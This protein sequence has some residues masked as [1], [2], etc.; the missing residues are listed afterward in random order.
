VPSGDL[1][2]ILD[3]ALD[4]LLADL[5]RQKLAAAG[6]PRLRRAGTPGTR[7]IPA[8]VRRAVWR[9]DGGRCA[10]QGPKG[11]CGERAF[12]EFHHVKPFAAGGETTE[13]NLELRCRAHN[14][15]EADLFFGGPCIARER[16]AHCETY[17]VRTEFAPSG[18]ARFST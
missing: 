4:R 6:R 16:L 15:H 13:E 18:S 1:A 11:P 10:F 14:Q 5:D 7:H 9:R 17:S 2:A 3:R 8:A 12:V